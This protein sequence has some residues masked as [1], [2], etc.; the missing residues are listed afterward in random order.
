MLTPLRFVSLSTSH[1]KFLLKIKSLKNSKNR[2][3]NKKARS[4]SINA[5]QLPKTGCSL[6]PA[7]EI[8]FPSQRAPR[9]RT[10]ADKSQKQTKDA[11]FYKACQ[12][13]EIL[14]KYIGIP[15]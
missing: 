7:S 8:S 5:H 12:R 9:N 11:T 6:T 1:L 3:V 13:T 15:F 4:N 10:T 14:L 2:Q